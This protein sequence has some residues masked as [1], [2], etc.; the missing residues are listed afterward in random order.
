MSNV[1]LAQYG[2][3]LVLIIDG[4]KVT[5]KVEDQILRD[6]IKTVYKEFTEAKSKKLKDK[7]LKQLKSF[8]VVKTEKVKNDKKIAKKIE[9]KIEKVKKVKT[10]ETK[11]ET[12]VLK[13]MIAE[14]DKAIKKLQ[15]QLENLQKERPLSESKSSVSP[16]PYKGEY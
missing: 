13:E 15:E 16:R 6:S 9:K 12:K 10:K 2:Q 1:K 8:F 4:E 11:N 5:K 3:N 14:K 7:L